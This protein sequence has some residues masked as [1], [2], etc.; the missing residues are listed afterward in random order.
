MRWVVL[1]GRPVA[2]ARSASDRPPGRPAMACRMW[3]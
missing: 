3:W 2:A 1:R